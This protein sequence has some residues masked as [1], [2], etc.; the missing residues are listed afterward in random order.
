[1]A[2]KVAVLLGLAVLVGNSATAWVGVAVKV[3]KMG[4][5]VGETTNV[6]TTVGVTGIPGNKLQPNNA[7]IIATMAKPAWPNCRM[8]FAFSF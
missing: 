3:G 6:G 5:L 1:V 8:E 2:V 7:P 4:K